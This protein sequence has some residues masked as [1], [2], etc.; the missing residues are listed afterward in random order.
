MFLKTR[1]RAYLH[2]NHSGALYRYTLPGSASELLNQNFPAPEGGQGAHAL[3]RSSGKL[4]PSSLTAAA[5]PVC[6]EFLA[7]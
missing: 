5:A 7:I 1:S 3:I 6:A 4:V 2:R